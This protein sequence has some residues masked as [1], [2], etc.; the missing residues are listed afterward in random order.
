MGSGHRGPD[1]G[2]ATHEFPTVGTP[3]GPALVAYSSAAALAA[4]R[5]G[6][7]PAPVSSRTLA[8]TALVETGGRVVLDPGGSAGDG[9]RLPRPAVAA[10]GQG[11]VWLPAWR[12]ADLLAGLRRVARAG[13]G[14]VLDVRIPGNAG[15]TQRVDLVVGGT[16]EGRDARNALAHTL[17]DLATHPR[18]LA[19]CERIEI[20][21][22]RAFAA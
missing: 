17:R 3:Q 15:A 6:A 21:P 5:P 18:L 14:A 4:D 1:E 9:I 19:A 11:D 13:E 16:P 8:L 22:V 12:D 2:E 20:V 7:R 10:L